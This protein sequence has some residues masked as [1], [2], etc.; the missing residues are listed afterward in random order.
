MDGFKNPFD[1]HEG[2]QMISIVEPKQVEQ[3][4]QEPKKPKQ[5]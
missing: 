2:E 3:K 4:K 1:D 5:K